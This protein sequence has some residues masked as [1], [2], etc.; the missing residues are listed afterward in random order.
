MPKVIGSKQITSDGFQKLGMVS[1]GNRL[2]LNETSG[3]K[4]FP[5]QVS[6]SGGDV[7]SLNISIENA[8]IADVSPDG[9]ELL[10]STPSPPQTGSPFWSVPLPAGSPRRLGSVIGHGAVWGPR[11]QLVFGQ[12]NDLYAAEHDGSSPRKL[13][14]APGLPDSIAFSPDGT[15]IRFTAIDAIT[16]GS[17]IWEARADGSGLHRLLPGW[18]KP[19]N[20]CCGSWSS[21]GQYYV[22]DSVRNGASNIWTIAERSSFWYKS[23]RTPVQLTAG[24]LAFYSGIPSKD[25]KRLFVLGMQQRGELVRYDAR[26]GDFVPFLGG[27]SAGEADFSR[28]GKWVT[29]VSY[30]E[31]TIWR[32]R[33]DGSER[34]QLTYSSMRAGLPHWSPDGQQIA[35]VGI[36]PAKPWKIFLISKDGGTASAVTTDED[37]TE[38]DP[39]WSPDGKSL[40]FGHSGDSAERTFIE[41][42][43]LQTRH[44]SR[45]PGSQGVFASRWSPDGHY[46]AGE[47]FDG[48]KLLL[49][50]LKTQ[51]W[52]QLAHSNFVGYLA[53][54]ADSRYLYFDTALESNPVFRRVHITDGKFETIVDLKRIRMFPSQFGPGSWTGLGPG[55]TPL[56]V[57]DTSAQEIYALDLQLP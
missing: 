25:G 53:W 47:S 28:D 19:P 12:G 39:A 57:R 3:P 54:S 56:F 34:L 26:S 50:D 48:S 33:L 43:D 49:L 18:S 51:Q 16:N 30:P 20:E 44:I 13:L 2:Y 1:D 21:D 7:A 35:F 6:S 52:R 24:P 38:A 55:D 17:E 40:A 5:V 45:L 46:I 27:I 32:S 9:S 31:Y 4:L 42:F 37:A 11:G 41:M 36:T 10:V 29:Y 8:Y 15:R 23:S 22:F 14:T